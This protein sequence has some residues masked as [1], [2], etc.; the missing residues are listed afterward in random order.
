MSPLHGPDLISAR[1]IASTTAYALSRGISVA[2]LETA[3]GLPLHQLLAS[4]T[5]LPVTLRNVLWEELARQ[6]PGTAVAF[7]MV[8]TCGFS[9]LGG[10]AEMVRVAPDLRCALRCLV[11]NSDLLGDDITFALEEFAHSCAFR[12]SHRR[13]GIGDDHAGEAAIALKLR[14]FRDALGPVFRVREIDIA[15]AANGPLARYEQEFG[16]VPRFECDDGVS[17]VFDRALL[18]RS[19]STA[20]VRHFQTLQM[21]F[22]LQRRLRREACGETNH[23]ERLQQA[24]AQRAGSGDYSVQGVAREAGMSVRSAQRV[25]ATQGRPLRHLIDDSRAAIA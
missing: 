18:E 10:L 23:H 21:H 15:W 14:L 6:E 9:A 12:L 24:I 1:A 4:T 13:H 16:V 17:V 5:D 19:P 3:T 22:E 25:A 8:E 2:H 20:S 11:E 7:D